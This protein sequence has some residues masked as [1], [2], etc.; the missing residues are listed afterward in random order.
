MNIRT[1]ITAFITA[2]AIGSTVG[3]VMAQT[4][5]TYAA[6]D[7]QIHGRVISFDGAYTLQVRDDQGYVDD[8]QLHQGTVIN[9][10]GITLAPGMVV[11][12]DGYN[13]GSYFDANQID[14]P[15]TF[16]SGVPYYLGHP[17]NYYGPTDSL[18]FYFGHTGWWHGAY[19]AAP[20]IVNR[21]AYV[22]NH[23]APHRGGIGH[24]HG[25]VAAPQ[26]GGFGPR[27]PIA[28]APVPH[29]GF[30]H[31]GR[32]PG[33]FPHAGGAPGGFPHAGGG[34]GGGARHH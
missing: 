24:G 6:Q 9:P 31:A 19:P 16:Y 14:T 20:V 28:H 4:T 32:A 5:P 11:S 34:H 25:Y 23:A 15:Y 22:G 3:P 17:W 2:S 30:P 29:G 13:A 10:T 26:H 8:V 1:L 33:G 12:V 27:A 21:G 7:Q 18:N